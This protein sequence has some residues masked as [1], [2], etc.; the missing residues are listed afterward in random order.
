MRYT[1]NPDV[2]YA[3]THEWARLE[4]NAVL[5]GVSDFAQQ[6]MSDVVYV[7]LPVV[8]DTV[9]RG[10]V[11]GTLES[12]KSVSEVYSPVTGE[13]VEVNEELLEHP[14]W[15][16]QDPYGKAWLAKLI[17]ADPAELSAL[18]DADAYQATLPQE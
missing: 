4:G 10:E 12:V 11:L 14:E 5:V 7:E 2:K 17:S 8:G 3:T 15:V 13:V 18:L 9:S 1:I 16:N 6:A